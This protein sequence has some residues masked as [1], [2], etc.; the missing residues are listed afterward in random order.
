MLAFSVLADSAVEHYRGSFQNRVMYAPLAVAGLTLA[1]CLFGRLDPRAQKHDVR[2]TIYASAAATGVAGLGFHYNILKRP[3]AWSW[4]NAF[5][6]APIGA[7]MAL[8]LAGFLG[9][10]AERV[11]DTPPMTTAT[12]S[13]IVSIGVGAPPKCAPLPAATTTKKRQGSYAGWRTITISSPTGQR[14][15]ARAVSS[16]C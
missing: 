5:F 2:D 13:T 8:A 1:A 3:G 11:R 15:A 7:P 10:G 6:A 16:V 12:V 14:P 9:R 4:L